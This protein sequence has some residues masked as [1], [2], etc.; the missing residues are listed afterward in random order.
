MMIGATR[1]C[2]PEASKPSSSAR[3]PCWKIQTSA[4]KLAV[5]LIRLISTALIGRRT[6]PKVRNRTMAVTQHHDRD[7]PRHRLA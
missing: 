1:R 5:M 2:V 3:W 7:R 6:D 4:P